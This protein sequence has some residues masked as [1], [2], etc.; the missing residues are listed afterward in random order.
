LRNEDAIPITV[1]C[2]MMMERRN[3]V[4][5]RPLLVAAA[6]MALH[7]SCCSPPARR[8]P[9]AETFVD[10]LQLWRS[11]NKRFGSNQGSKFESNKDG[12]ESTRIHLVV[13]RDGGAKA[14][15]QSSIFTDDNG[16]Q[17]PILQLYNT[18]QELRQKVEQLE[19][20]VRYLRTK[21]STRIVLESFEGENRQASHRAHENDD[22]VGGAT[23]SSSMSFPD[24]TAMWCDELEGDSCPLEPMIS[25][26]E[27]LRDRA[28]WLVGLLLLQSFSGIILA[29]NEGLLTRHPVSTCLSSSCP[30]SSSS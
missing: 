30:W 20:E 22:M 24:D 1:R 4:R 13:G 14:T 6:A 3:G 21:V 11:S 26:G 28:L 2:S 5:R 29:H 9:P 16:S 12:D 8:G 27:A 19:E 15:D 17:V 18:N 7:S 25:F 10:A 23:G